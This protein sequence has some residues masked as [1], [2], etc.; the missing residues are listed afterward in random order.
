MGQGKTDDNIYKKLGEERITVNS[1]NI[2]APSILAADFGRLGEQVQTVAQAGAEYIHI[3]VM[4]GMFV[5]S[6][7]FGIPV[8]A[9]I[10]SFTDKVFDVHMMVEE[11]GRYAADMKEA[12]A[13][14]LCVHQEACRHLDRTIHQIRDLGMKAGVALNPATPLDTL[15]YILPEVDMVLLMSVNPGFGGQRF[16]E[17][18]VD[19]VARLREMIDRKGL[20]TMIEVDGGVN[21]ETGKR[22]VDAGADVLVAG[23]FVFK[24]PDPIQTIKD[25]K[26]L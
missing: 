18:S 25:L 19:K 8:I 17:H 16:I 26:A 7:S 24:S 12:G 13:D 4:D 20:S 11:P 9:G 22:L 2:L 6:I 3:D 5:P 15:E 10:R 1:E 14:L 23:N 21:L